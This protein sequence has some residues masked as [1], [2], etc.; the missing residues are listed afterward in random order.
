MMEEASDAPCPHCKAISPHNGERT[1]DSYRISYNRTDEYPGF[2]TLKASA[3]RGCRFCGLLRHALQDKYSDKKIAE[4]ESDFH[5]S[6][7]A[8]WPLEWSGQV[9]VGGGRF[10]TEE[11]WPYRD[12]SQTLDQ[13]LGDFYVLQLVVWPHPPRRNDCSAE[14]NCSSIWFSVYADEGEWQN[15][16][17]L[18]LL[19]L[20]RLYSITKRGLETEKTRFRDFIECQCSTNI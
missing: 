19:M 3:R 5:P 8:K 20:F 14:S 16:V 17:M 2:L 10:R 1:H 12:R 15:S 11:G 4:A 6:T 9:T 13:S 18:G 7:R